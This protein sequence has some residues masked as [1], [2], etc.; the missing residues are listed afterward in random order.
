MTEIDPSSLRAFF[1]ELADAAAA[2][3]LPRFRGTG[4]VVNKLADADGTAYD[5]VTAA[6]REGESAIRQRIEATFPDHAILGEEHGARAGTSGYRWVIDPV[7]GTRAFVSGV[8]V[9]TT[10]VGLE[11]DG[12]LIGGLIDQPWLKERWIGIKAHGTE[13]SAPQGSKPASVSS[14]TSLP[15]ARFTVTDMRPGSYFTDEE[16][17]RLYAVSSPCRIVRQ[18]LDAYGFALIASGHLDLCIEAGLN[19]HDIAAIVPVIEAAGGVVC[20]WDGAPVTEAFPRGRCV[21]AATQALADAACT[22]LTK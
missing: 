22:I 20:T 15:D 13:Y 5:P 21:I 14:C 6:D 7:D 9:W 1:H 12:E 10:L 18:G 16:L 4:D 11:R 8:P 2:E 17:D 19:W 3:T